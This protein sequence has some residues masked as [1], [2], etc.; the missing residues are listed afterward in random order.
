MKKLF[1]LVALLSLCAC[2]GGGGGSDDTPL[3]TPSGDDT[4]TDT[5]NGNNNGGNTESQVENRTDSF[6]SIAGIDGEMYVYKYIDQNDV[7]YAALIPKYVK[8]N[9]REIIRIQDNKLREA[10]LLEGTFLPGGNINMV[11]APGYNFTVGDDIKDTVSQMLNVDIENVYTLGVGSA[12]R[13]YNYRQANNY[14]YG[15]VFNGNE[16]TVTFV[17]TA[18]AMV[19][20]GQGIPFPDSENMRITLGYELE[21]T[22]YF[23]LFVGLGNDQ[24]IVAGIEDVRIYLDGV[25]KYRTDNPIYYQVKAEDED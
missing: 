22:P 21:N 3:T 11:S 2:G 8:L 4:D 12:A 1:I 10:I 25:L 18:L 17:E 6:A 14:D 9:E 19:D 13:V 20:P 23:K 24:G 7:G 15:Y 5:T 16:T